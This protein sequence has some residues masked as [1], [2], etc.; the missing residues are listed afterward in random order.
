MMLT[1]FCVIALAY[2]QLLSFLESHLTFWTSTRSD[3]SESVI[4]INPFTSDFSQYTSTPIWF[5]GTVTGT[6]DIH[7]PHF[8][9]Y[10]NNSVFLSQTTT[11][12]GWIGQDTVTNHTMA[13]NVSVGNVL[14]TSNAFES[15]SK[16]H[17]A[18]PTLDLLTT[19]LFLTNVDGLQ[20]LLSTAR[21]LILLLYFFF[22]M[23]FI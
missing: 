2:L 21:P 1:T 4:T 18:I 14:F 5:T 16:L 13:S 7:L 9:L 20:H 3:I 11:T 6:N 23:H 10:F 12:C 22:V 15:V 19:H 8:G 17:K